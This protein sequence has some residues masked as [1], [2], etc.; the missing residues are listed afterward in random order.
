MNDRVVGN[1]GHPS[2]L[3]RYF[4]LNGRSQPETHRSLAVTERRK[5]A[6]LPF[7]SGDRALLTGQKESLQEEKG[8]KEVAIKLALPS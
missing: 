1:T 3:L 2:K 7:P 4:P 6:K 5:C 8:G